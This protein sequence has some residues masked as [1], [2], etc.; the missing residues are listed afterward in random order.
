MIQGKAGG[1]DSIAAP[2]G[3]GIPAGQVAQAVPTGH[4][5]RKDGPG[6]DSVAEKSVFSVQKKSMYWIIKTSKGFA[7]SSPSRERFFP[8]ELQAPV[9]SIREC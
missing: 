4:R 2:P 7:G 8:A 9:L 6:D 1:E 3:P 5:I